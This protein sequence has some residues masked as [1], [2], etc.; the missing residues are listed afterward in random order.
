[1]KMSY[2]LTEIEKYQEEIA[3]IRTELEEKQAENKHL[4][5]KVE[6]LYEAQANIRESSSKA[7]KE[8]IQSLNFQISR[9]KEEQLLQ[10]K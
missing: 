7:E 6:S 5:R 8:E 1:M 9:L 2:H 4:T 10:K 3:V